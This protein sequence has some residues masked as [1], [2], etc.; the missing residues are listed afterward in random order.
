MSFLI[1]PTPVK[2]AP[3]QG[4]T[5]FGGGATSLSTWVDPVS[6]VYGSVDY[7]DSGTNYLSTDS[8][9]DAF[10]LGSTNWTIEFWWLAE[11]GNNRGDHG[12][13]I[14]GDIAG[15]AAYLAY[16][17]GGHGDFQANWPSSNEIW[18]V[19]SCDTSTWCHFAF[20]KNGTGSGNTTLYK[21]GT[22]G[23]NSTV[24]NSLGAWDGTQRL[25]NAPSPWTNQN[26]RGKVSNFRVSNIAR[27]TSD[28]TAPTNP[29]VADGNTVLLTMQSPTD[30]TYC[31]AG[32]ITGTTGSVTASSS[33][34]WE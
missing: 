28:F 14:G 24:S 19:T 21:N 3:I 7:P 13:F 9:D 12:H 11:D 1:Y 27:Y 4:M 18:S 10:D 25:G 17:D 29:F 31:G 5:G 23:N 6:Y 33:H 15:S 26:V 8:L 34:P 20:S 2:M 32:A 22:A 16:R 30:I